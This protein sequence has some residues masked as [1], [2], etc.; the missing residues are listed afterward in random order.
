VLANDI[1]AA[2]SRIVSGPRR[3]RTPQPRPARQA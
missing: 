2:L 3:I 1:A